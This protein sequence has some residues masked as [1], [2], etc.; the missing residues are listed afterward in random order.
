MIVDSAFPDA[1]TLLEGLPNPILVLDE[2]DHIRFANAAAQDFFETGKPALLRSRFSEFVP[3]ASPAL[4]AIAEVRRSGGTL[5]EHAVSVGT[6]R[7]G[8]ERRVDIQVS[9]MNEAPEFIAIILFSRSMA[10]K[11]DR[12]LTHRGAARSVTGLAAMLAHEIKNPL[13][14]I[15]GAA[16]LI[17]PALSGEDRALARLICDESDRIRDLVDRMEVF[18]DERPPERKPVNIHSVLDHVKAVTLSAS[19]QGLT[20]REEYDP[21]LPPVAGSR[22]Q[23]VQAFL[24][25]LKNAAEAI[26]ATRERGEIV[27]STAFR[28]GVRLTIAASGEKVSLPLEVRVRDT[29][30]GIPDDIRPHVFEPFVTTKVGGRGLGLALVAKIVKDHGGVVECEPDGR[31]TLFR[32]LLPM[33][34]EAPGQRALAREISA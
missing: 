7:W 18:S 16:Q 21:S 14:G 32:V 4:S 2:K 1:A 25:L 33:M 23:L 17:E 24:N 20:I 5:N 28:P 19:A 22:D 8:G 11:I 15:R 27:L 26:E 29:G 6:P 34:K 30:G 10:H 12:Q 13:A 9:V 3:F 31:G